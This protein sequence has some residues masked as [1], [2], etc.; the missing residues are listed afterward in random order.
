MKQAMHEGTTT[1]PMLRHAEIV[2][3]PSTDI[4]ATDGGGSR[5]H[6]F[7]MLDLAV[8]RQAFRPAMWYDEINQ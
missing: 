1:T 8:D 4:V 3:D 2:R 6:L 7:T 5:D